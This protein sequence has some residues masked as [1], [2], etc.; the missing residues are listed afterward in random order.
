EQR[1]FLKALAKVGA[2]TAIASNEVARL[3]NRLYG[4]VF[5]SKALPGKVLAPLEKAGFLTTEKSTEGRGA[6]PHAVQPT[7]QFTKEVLL[8]LLRAS[9]K[10][11]DARLREML[12]R[13]LSEIIDE[14]DST[15]KNSK[16][17]ALEA[18]V[19]RITRLLDLQ[20]VGWRLRQRR[21]G[22]AE[23]DVLVESD[24]LIFSRWQ[25]Q[26]KNTHRVELEDIAK[27]VG[28]TFYLKS[29]VIMIVT[30][31]K[32]GKPARDYAT[33]IIEATNLHIILLDGK[34]LARLRVQPS[35]IVEIL[36]RE[37]KNAM[38]LKELKVP[39]EEI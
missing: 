20:F 10:G 29:N 22:G 38:Q 36:D 14:L 16:G 17:K 24:R 26:C 1:D 37:A 3:A 32:I 31:G 15:D 25:I 11:L 7:E 21:T 23:V 8:P 28:L 4:T 19:L 27:E 5:D 34:D 13:P 33:G 6:K 12:Y 9:S 39:L 35:A 18:L 2:T 30:T